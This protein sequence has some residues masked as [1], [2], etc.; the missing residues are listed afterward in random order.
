MSEQK[1]LEEV[2]KL[3]SNDITK[4]LLYPFLLLWKAV[5][6]IGRYFSKPKN[7][8][9]FIEVVAGFSLY[10]WGFLNWV[11]GP[12]NNYRADNPATN[13]GIYHILFIVLYCI[14][15]FVMIITT[16]VCFDDWK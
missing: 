3:L 2:G 13:V 4:I 11:S 14:V 5:I 16:L 12:I 9:R 6:G 1:W 15:G 7:T 8:V 10:I